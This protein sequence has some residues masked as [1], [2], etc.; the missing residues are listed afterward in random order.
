VSTAPC[1]VHIV[2]D[3]QRLYCEQGAEGH[4]GT[5]CGSRSQA[6][7]DR[8]RDEGSWCDPEWATSD[9]TAPI[10]EMTSPERRSLLVCECGAIASGFAAAR[11][12][13]DRRTNIK[14]G[15]PVSWQTWQRVDEVGA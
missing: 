3:G 4:Y 9:E 6:D 12:A 11:C 13:L 2:V 1:P 10:D 14:G 8:L 7:Y 5:H 15:C